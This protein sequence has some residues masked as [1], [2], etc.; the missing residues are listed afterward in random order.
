MPSES[1]EAAI[2][3]VGS[4]VDLLRNATS[5]PTVFP[6]A[7]EFTN[8]RS[9]QAAWRTTCALLD[10]SHH[11]TDLYLTGPGALEL[12]SHTGVN[13]FAHF[14]VDRAKQFV[15][16]NASGHLIGDAIAFHLGEHH[17]DLVGHPMVLDWVQYHLET[18]DYDATAERDPNSI[19]RTDRPPTVYRYELQGP[20]APALLEELQGST[21]PEVKFFAMGHLDLA[22][23]HVRALRHG[24]AGQPGFELFGPWEDGQRVLDALLGVGEEFGLVRAGAKAYSTSNLESGWV[25]SPLPAIYSGD[26]LRGYR[27]WLPAAA[28]GSL[29]GSLDSADISDYYVTPYDLSYGRNIAFDHDFIGRDA[30]A[31]I[32]EPARTKVTLVWD[33]EDV[34]RAIDSLYQPG[35]AAKYLDMPKARYALFQADVVLKDGEP[36]GVSMDCGYLYNERAM[37]SLATVDVECAAPG[38]EVTVVW[39]EK[40]NSAKPAVEPHEQ[41][42]IRATVAPAPYVRFAREAYRS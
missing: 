32:G 18:G 41:V 8:W 19:V 16:V 42:E 6:V 40:P 31:A 14:P 7:P 27:E 12:L 29:G 3:S 26:E 23:H 2:N 17:F 21:L 36:A 38:T 1:L 24:M 10:Q 37:V 5:P 15:A 33:H 35:P 22:G 9:E 30:L 34:T 28:A 13:S 4:P 11:M 39:G 25:P 20:T